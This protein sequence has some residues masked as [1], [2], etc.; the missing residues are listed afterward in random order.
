MWP[1]QGCRSIDLIL[2]WLQACGRSISAWLPRVT[3]GDIFP[4]YFAIDGP[5]TR[6][7]SVVVPD[8]DTRA[9]ERDCFSW[10][11]NFDAI[12]GAPVKLIIVDMNEHRFGATR[13]IV[14]FRNSPLNL[15]SRFVAYPSHNLAVRVVYLN[16]E[17]I[18]LL[19]SIEVQS[20]ESTPTTHSALG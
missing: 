10:D 14:S 1:G 16:I 13:T 3:S 11:P 19:L 8:L 7:C 20:T 2:L 15:A 9:A 18:G 12:I 5:D 6:V 4:T 17:K